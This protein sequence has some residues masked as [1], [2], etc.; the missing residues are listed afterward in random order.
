MKLQGDKATIIFHSCVF[1]LSRRE[2]RKFT[3]CDPK[4]YAQHPISVRV[5][6]IEPRERTS[7]STTI[8]PED[9]RYLTIEHGEEVL[10]DSRADVPIDMEWWRA[11]YEEF[12]GN[13]AGGHIL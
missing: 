13:K 10:Y 12:N 8:T 3:V 4:P 2:V 11:K 9:H 7:K 5:E 6:F 1:G